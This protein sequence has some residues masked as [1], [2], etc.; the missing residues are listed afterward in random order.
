MYYLLMTLSTPGWWCVVICAKC[1]QNN[2]L[3]FLPLVVDAQLLCRIN[4]SINITNSHWCTVE[5]FSYQNRYST[6]SETGGARNM[7]EVLVAAVASDDFFD[8]VARNNLGGSLGGKSESAFCWKRKGPRKETKIEKPFLKSK[9]TIFNQKEQFSLKFT[10]SQI[11]MTH[12]KSKWLRWPAA[13][14]SAFCLMTWHLIP[15]S[16]VECE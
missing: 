3:A 16:E 13:C 5:L 15:I 8:V 4:P 1:R 10:H 9:R 2:W 12:L 7:V 14:I 11:K 6:F